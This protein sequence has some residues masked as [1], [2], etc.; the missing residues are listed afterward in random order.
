MQGMRGGGGGAQAEPEPD[1]AEEF[2]DKE[3]AAQ[4]EQ[5]ASQAQADKATQ[6]LQGASEEFMSSLGRGFRQTFGRSKA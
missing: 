2:R 4:R 6:Q 1:Y 5:Q 3:L